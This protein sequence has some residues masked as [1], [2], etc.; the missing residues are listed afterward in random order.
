MVTIPS[1]LFDKP[2]VKVSLSVR[3]ILSVASFLRS[4]KAAIILV[5]ASSSMAAF[6]EGSHEFDI[7]SSDLDKNLKLLENYYQQVNEKLNSKLKGGA[8]DPFQP[9]VFPQEYS[10]TPETYGLHSQNPIAQSNVQK[11]LLGSG[12]SKPV[13]M[14]SVRGRIGMLPAMQFRGF[15]RMDGKSAALLDITGVGS[16]VV[17]IGDKVGMGRMDNEDETVIRIVEIN[18]LNVTVEVGSLG[19]RVVV[20]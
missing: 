17:K 4:V 12:A 20:Q 11:T 2:S 16:V 5:I 6:G 9:L 14:R 13:V 3:C 7:A 19:E 18:S 15:M 1:L 10:S 8:R